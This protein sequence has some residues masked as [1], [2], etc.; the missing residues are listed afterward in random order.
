MQ[1][2]LREALGKLHQV[3]ANF[4]PVGISGERPVAHAMRC[5]CTC[6]HAR[7]HAGNGGLLDAAATTLVPS[8]NPCLI[9]LSVSMCLL[10]QPW[11]ISLG[12][13]TAVSAPSS[14]ELG[15]WGPPTTAGGWQHVVPAE[16][17]QHSLVLVWKL[18]ASSLGAGGHQTTAGGFGVCISDE[19]G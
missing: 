12:V 9:H 6:R 16:W 8:L 17:V 19:D 15:S 4:T 13:G 11:R 1:A 2:M 14:G 7:L 18:G 3:K 5:N 10:L